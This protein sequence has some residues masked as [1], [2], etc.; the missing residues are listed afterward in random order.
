[1]IK[2]EKKLFDEE[3]D[4]GKI[5][6]VFFLF[7][8][9]SLLTSWYYSGDAE[10]VYKN[11]F[12]LSDQNELPDIGPIK[13]P[14]NN[15]AYEIKIVSRL[16]MSSWAFIEGEILDNQKEYLYSFGKELW[17]ESGYDSDGQWIENNNDYSIDVT[18]PKAGTYYLHL[19]TSF[20]KAPNSLQVTVARSRGSALPHFWF[21]VLITLIGIGLNESKNKTLWKAYQASR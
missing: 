19:K 3:I 13:V 2:Y 4:L 20:N 11:S 18:F 16:P 21:G 8:I 7:G 9:L 1:V 12:V 14:K 6:S 17:Y 5:A 15:T 10:K